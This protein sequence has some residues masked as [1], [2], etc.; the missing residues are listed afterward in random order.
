MW[1]LWANASV[2][3]VAA[4]SAAYAW[5]YGGTMAAPLTAT[6]PWLYAMLFEVMLVFPQRH[7]YES[8]YD[9]RERV[10]RR[11]KRDPLVWVSTALIA[12][13]IIPFFNTGLCPVCDY[14]AILS[15]MRQEPPI[16]FL[17]Y[18]VNRMHHL[19]V[20]IWFV[21]ALTAMI[22]VKHSLIKSGK[23]LLL[24]LMVWNGVAL[25]VLGFVQQAAGAPGPLWSQEGGVAQV[26]T[27]FSTFGYPNMA[28]DYFTT[29][30]GISIALWR[31]QM[32]A[33]RK[34]NSSDHAGVDR[35]HRGKFWRKHFYLIPATLFFFAAF[36]TLSRAAIMLVSVLTVVYFIHSFISILARM[37]KVVKVKS[38]AVSL[39]CIVIVSL[40]A[41]M[42]TSD[43][44]RAE[45][46]T[47][48][49]TSVL[50][51]VTGRGQYHARVAT[52]IWKDNF[53]FGCGGW[54][55]KHFC[56]P[57]MTED[58]LKQIQKVGGINVHND[59]LQFMAEHGTVGFGLMVAVV[60]L[61]LVPTGRI[62]R[63]LARATRFKKAK[64]LPPKPAAIFVF[65]APAFCLLMTAL[66]TLIHGFGDCP[67]RSPAV[68]SLFFISL[69]A[70]DGFLPKLESDD[71][72]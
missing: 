68:L 5:I 71:N 25:A 70:V 35:T 55:Y 1:I 31:W 23:R 13:L 62:W 42:F 11:M 69:A 59:Y 38:A 37:P 10:W 44:V 20:V 47:L 63:R 6:I 15:G 7:S 58:E 43:G 50:D 14:P 57:N 28:G 41:Y 26:G 66:A 60:V 27:F 30:F 39:V 19:N 53:L 46:E 21:P 12:L 72:D 48:D 4:L 36:S 9:A 18:C 16:P 51:R 45:V 64:D 65:P 56:I 32:E 34:E 61:L 52:E 8:V 24:S 49:A 40:L 17:P 54:G 2:L 67:M 22:A 3:A 29:L 33:V